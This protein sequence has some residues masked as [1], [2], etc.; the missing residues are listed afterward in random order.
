MILFTSPPGSCMK[1]CCNF[2]EIAYNVHG[3][4]WDVSLSLSVL[5]AQ[6]FLD[7]M[8]KLDSNSLNASTSTKA[9]GFYMHNLC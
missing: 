9:I 5:N 4:I 6:I 8:R 7:I 1:I 2:Q 3:I